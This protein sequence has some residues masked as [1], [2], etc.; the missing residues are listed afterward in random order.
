M[1]TSETPRLQP[2]TPAYHLCI[3]DDAQL[4]QLRSATLEILDETGIHCPSEKTLRIYADHGARVD[5]SSK[6]V[7]I[8]PE[9]VLGALANAPRFYTMGA[10]SAAFDLKLDGKSTYL[11]T[12]GCG[13]E[14]IDF[15]SRT[16]RSSRKEDVA[17]MARIADALPAIGFYWPI[18]SAQDFPATAPLHELDASFRN[19]LKHIQSETIMGAGLAHYAVEMARII[20][21]DDGSL[22]SRPPLSLLIC[23]IAPLGLDRDGMESAMVL[24]AAGLP[25]GFM[26]M[27]NLGSTG[28][29]TPAGT[30][31]CADA[32]IVAAMV[33]IQ[34][35]YPGAPVFHSL[36]PGIMHPRT[37]AYLATAWEGTLLYAAGVEMA[38]H[39][40]VPTL[41]GVFATD[42]L[43]PGWQ[44][45]GDAASSLMLCALTGAETGSGLGLLESCTLLYPEEIILDSDIYHRV[46]L[47]AGGLDTSRQAMALDI[48]KDVGPR[49]H[50]LR[51]RHTRDA[52]RKLH[53]SDLTSQLAQDN[54]IR[55]PI[56]VARDKVEWIMQNHYPE[57]LQEAQ[58]KEL[59]RILVCADK[60]FS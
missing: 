49:G 9:I 4:T 11:A 37:G 8:P 60:E 26:S 41:A 30:L 40:G 1:N 7:R 24:A 17:R 21:A 46:R 54:S 36:M 10:R 42:A 59:K 50:F 57:P 44:S 16:R 6:I 48:I 12:D 13:V 18:V 20:T 53:F 43:E 55:D 19:T 56:A 47:E 23:C 38:H 52:L 45:A 34:M 29:A 58:Q 3:L 5:F 14:V 15:E 51:H 39:W 22:R 33:L 32:E 27:A 2:I 28:P 35:A 31:V 25:V